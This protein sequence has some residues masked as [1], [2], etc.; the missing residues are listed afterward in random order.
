VGLGDAENFFITQILV[1]RGLE[2]MLSLFYDGKHKPEEG[3]NRESLEIWA[4]A[5]GNNTTIVFCVVLIAKN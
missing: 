4:K 2:Q 5:F 3:C 1:G